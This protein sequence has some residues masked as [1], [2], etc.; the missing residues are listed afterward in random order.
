MTTFPLLSKIHGVVSALNNRNASAINGRANYEQEQ[1]KEFRRES[2]ERLFLQVV[3][4]DD[5]DIVGT[6]ISCMALNVSP[7]GL[8]VACDQR[9]PE[10]CFIDL[11]VDDSA[12]PGKFFLSSEVRWE[13]ENEPGEFQIGVA[14]LDGAATDIE[15]WRER[16]SS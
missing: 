16:Q 10:G 6:T 11:W 4:S 9:I 5:Q 1:R 13:S 15:E 7:G 3:Q 12:R 14:L 8:M 2:N